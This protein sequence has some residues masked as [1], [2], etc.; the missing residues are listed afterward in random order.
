MPKAIPLSGLED[1]QLIPA[2]EL[3]KAYL[4]S[5]RGRPGW[6]DREV[7]SS[8]YAIAGA[9]CV[10]LRSGG[11]P[12]IG[13]KLIPIGWVTPLAL[14]LLIIA[15]PVMW[16]L[17]GAGRTRLPFD[18][19]EQANRL[20]PGTNSPDG[21]LRKASGHVFLGVER[22]SGKQV[23]LS[24]NKVVQHLMLPG[25]TGSGKTAMILG[26]IANA[27]AQGSGVFEI[28]AKG[29]L[30][31]LQQVM[32]LARM[33][34]RD[35]DVRI[36]NF[37]NSDPYVSEAFNSN[38]F[39]MLSMAPAD[40]ITSLINSMRATIGKDNQSFAARG[41]ALVSSV[42]SARV[43]LRDNLGIP[44][45]VVELRDSIMNLDNLIGLAL[46]CDADGIEYPTTLEF[47]EITDSIWSYL[48]TYMGKPEILAYAQSVLNINVNA[49][50]NLDPKHTRLPPTKFDPAAKAELQKQ[51]G[52]ATFS[53]TDAWQNILADYKRIFGCL[54]GDITVDDAVKNRRIVIALLP[55]LGKSKDATMSASRILIS[56]IRGMASRALGTRT[57][58]NMKEL[59]E[60]QITKANSPFLI[61]FEEAGPYV[62]EGMD[63]LYQQAR[64]LNFWI[65]T[66][67]QDIPGLEK[68][69]P[70]IA[71]SIVGNANYP[72]FMRLQ[73][74]TFTGKLAREMGE[75]EFT[76][77]IRGFEEK[78]GIFDTKRS[79][80]SQN[81]SVERQERVTFR[82]LQSQTVGQATI[83]AEGRIVRMN[84]FYCE[85]LSCVPTHRM[86]SY[87]RRFAA[88]APPRFSSINLVRVEND[89]GAKSIA[90]AA[91]GGGLRTP[92]MPAVK[93]PEVNSSGAAAQVADKMEKA[94]PASPI[95]SARQVPDDLQP[96]KLTPATAAMKRSSAI[97]T[98]LYSM[99]VQS[100][101]VSLDQRLE[102]DRTT[103]SF[104]E[105][106]LSKPGP[107]NA[108]DEFLN[109]S[110]HGIRLC[111]EPAATMDLATMTIGLVGLAGIRGRFRRDGKLPPY[112]PQS[113][114]TR[115]SL[116][117]IVSDRDL[118]DAVGAE[119]SLDEILAGIGEPLGDEHSPP[120]PTYYEEDDRDP[121]ASDGIPD[122]DDEDESDDGFHPP[123]AFIP[124]PPLA[125]EIDGL[126][127]RDV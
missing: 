69:D 52:F 8:I 5:Q 11:I 79:V 124:P 24:N 2:S 25:T 37:L 112:L 62:Q 95:F 46:G 81:I 87:I 85:P 103:E 34:G 83:I 117:H 61:V 106:Q 54:N 32:A 9:A 30:K 50:K 89:Q 86:N 53:Y 98:D 28:D 3:I 58:G 36:L 71:R 75:Q 114:S 60:N 84:A 29:D 27:L 100:L 93:A 120:T 122:T 40:D 74:A 102:Q 107:V 99:F 121:F 101:K 33:F 80:D 104:I 90:P 14:V 119:S 56:N 115:R 125:D 76:A 17:S 41:T 77:L 4:P 68:N 57:Y 7:I 66:A 12:F 6:R 109:L 49:L 63:Q 64:G 44:L 1:D 51:H 15:F 92:G 70:G 91:T 10:I 82:D 73:D 38:T 35:A 65:V 45:S 111:G 88:W 59:V 47:R 13:I 20:D 22:A 110:Y 26:L 96:V 31:F 23:W 16:L 127:D 108:W 21:K 116:D 39:N 105:L 72:M 118:S 97:G 42:T 113:W 94:K 78:T 67:F 126:L 43:W 19:P 123:V 55:A 48:V 18:M